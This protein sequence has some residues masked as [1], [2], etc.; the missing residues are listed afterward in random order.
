MYINFQIKQIVLFLMTYD[1]IKRILSYI[2][3]YQN[4]QKYE[5]VAVRKQV[6]RFY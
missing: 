4:L 1:K 2:M 5:Y 6:G 3:N